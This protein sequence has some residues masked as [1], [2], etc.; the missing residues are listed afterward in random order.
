MNLRLSLG[1]GDDEPPRTKEQ[2][3]YLGRSKTEY[4]A[5]KERIL[6]GS[7]GMVVVVEFAQLD[8][9][10]QACACNNVLYAEIRET[11]PKAGLLKNVHYRATG[12]ASVGGSLC[13]SADNIPRSKDQRSCP[14]LRQAD[15][16][17][18]YIM[19]A[20]RFGL[21]NRSEYFLFLYLPN[22]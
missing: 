1:T 19:K 17:G 4:K 9:D 7:V 22:L 13:A 10:R 3:Y 12:Q 15:G 20:I 5:R 2:K 16:C 8:R 18:S 21:E 6:V 14:W 11:D